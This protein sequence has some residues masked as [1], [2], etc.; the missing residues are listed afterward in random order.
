MSAQRW[1]ATGSIIFG[2]LKRL[3][4]LAGIVVG[5]VAVLTASVVFL[6]GQL[7]TIGE[8]WAWGIVGTFAATQLVWYV[9]VSYV[10]AKPVRAGGSQHD[11]RLL[12]IALEL[13]P[14]DGDAMRFLCEGSFGARFERSQIEPMERFA[15]EFRAPE[16]EF[17]DTEVEGAKQAFIRAWD[18]CDSLLSPNVYVD[19]RPGDDR[20]GTTYALEYPDLQ[21]TGIPEAD[22]A[23]EIAREL[24]SR[25]S[26]VCE[27]HREFIAVAVRRVRS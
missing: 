12:E 14:T 9:A 24:D 6:R 7:S 20:L 1:R 16:R 5:A 15:R 19:P 25:A 17:R 13:L 21:G 3:N 26:R 4:S 11:N 22:K 18:D 27:A 23:H 10:R 8:R 2:D